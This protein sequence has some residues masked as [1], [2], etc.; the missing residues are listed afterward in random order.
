M[1]TFALVFAVIIVSVFFVLAF[2]NG[3]DRAETEEKKDAEEQQMKD[4]I[5]KTDDEWREELTE[6]QFCIMRLQGTERAFTGKYYD[7][8]ETGVYKCAACGQ[9][10]FKS[11]A[12]YR[13]GSGWPGFF[14]PAGEDALIMKKD[15]SHGMVRTEVLCSRCDAHLGHVFED[16]PEPTGLRF[17]INSA[18]LEFEKTGDNARSNNPSELE[19]ATLGAG[20]F[21]C[22]EAVYNRSD[23]VESVS[24][25]YMGG[26]TE[27]PTYKQV[28][29]GDTGHVEVAQVKFDPDRLSFEKLL[30]VF[31]KIHDPTSMDRQGADVGSQYRSVIF[32]HTSEQKKT[33]EESRDKLSKKLADPVV[34]KILPAKKFYEAEKY[35]QDYYENN[36]DAP[37]CR[38][39]I[40]PKL[41]KIK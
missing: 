36:K 28:S 39:V 23:G 41:K 22:T 5:I 21:W 20:C 38:I 19:T 29:T 30:E 24:V 25:G 14:A 11:D 17:C 35:H 31:W 2:V 10:L 26:E 37:Y 16:G 34:T 4:K 1:K 9:V 40:E 3:E 6:E 33:A 18:A 13:S 32:Y 8:Y 7:H 12:K 27:N 15:T